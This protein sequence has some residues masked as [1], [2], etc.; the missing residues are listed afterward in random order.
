MISHQR[1]ALC[2][3]PLVLC[4]RIEYCSNEGT[5]ASLALTSFEGDQRRN[6]V[7][8][9]RLHTAQIQ[10]YLNPT[11]V[12]TRLEALQSLR[13][14]ESRAQCAS[15]HRPPLTGI[16]AHLT[17]QQ[18]LKQ[19]SVAWSTDLAPVSWGV[20][21]ETLGGADSHMITLEGAASNN[22]HLDQQLLHLPAAARSSAAVD[23]V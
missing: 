11:S 9:D 17:M 3:L 4:V 2:K 7:Y 23:T 15:Q 6:A 13:P 5:P 14:A 21:R 10:S 1:E 8:C 22:Q 20:G 19:Q 18:N 16:N 12:L